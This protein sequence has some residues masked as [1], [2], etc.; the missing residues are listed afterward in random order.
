[1][2]TNNLDGWRRVWVYG[3]FYW[4]FYD[5]GVYVIRCTLSARDGILQMS[6]LSLKIIEGEIVGLLTEI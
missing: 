6:G 2:P 5:D 3:G 1:M 4:E